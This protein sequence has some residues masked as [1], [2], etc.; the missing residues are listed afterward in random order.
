MRK[1]RKGT[2]LALA[3]MMIATFVGGCG[4]GGD[5]GTQGTTAGSTAG[6]TQSGSTQ[7]GTQTASGEREK[8]VIG[9]Q[10]STNVE[11]Y[12]TN[13]FT[14]LLEEEMNIDIEFVILPA[15]GDDAK[16]KLS[17]MVSSGSKLPDVLAMEL[18]GTVAYDYA[19]KGVFLN[20]TD[21]FADKELA[22]NYWAI[23]EEDREVLMNTAKLADGNIY[24]VPGY[25]PMEW[26]MG[27]YR[28]WV[29]Q[30]WLDK[31]GLQKPTNTEEFYE[32]CKAFANNDPN[33]NGKKDEIA[34]VGSKEGWAQKPFVFMMNAFTYANPD[35]QYFALENGKVVPSF[36]KEE[37]KAGLEYIKKF[38]DEG[39]FSPLSFTQ[40]Q[41]QLK[42][43]IAAEGGMGGFVASGS[44]STFNGT[45]ELQAAMVLTQPIEGP[46]GNL[47]T[48]YNPTTSKTQWWIT[49][50]CTN[51][52][53][54]FKLGDL[55]Y[56]HDISV[57]SRFGEEGVDWTEDPEI[58]KNW[59]GENEKLLGM[60]T[61]M[62]IINQVWNVPQNKMWGQDFFGY[63]SNELNMTL[64]A[65]EKDKPT[66]VGA[67]GEEIRRVYTESYVTA[68]PDEA[69][70][71]INFTPEEAEKIANAK[72]AIDAYVYEAAVAFVTSNRPM[73]DWD[74]YLKELDDMGL[75]EYTAAMQAA[76]DRTK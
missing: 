68:F 33:G 53:L 28:M 61:Q 63:R 67:A 20:L 59:M 47:T 74:K 72:T 69:F 60:P 58:C 37:W 3:A 64:S 13:Y 11:D 27:A 52:E 50:D 62:V 26:N 66:D 21:Y 1:W 51:P 57:T 23:P 70:T 55:M 14:N 16:S 71:N 19:S 30:E 17:M 65:Y 22:P 76:Y 10:Q 48:P 9:L 29:N 56:R 4:N 42:A 18:T 15:G 2:A 44:G 40:D 38:V 39:L 41:A 45:P 6:S 73:S 35:K 12:E 54:A 24:C 32:V 31:L 49:K 34:V 8:I 43:L 36:T 46:E 75:E 25:N 7:E 5:K